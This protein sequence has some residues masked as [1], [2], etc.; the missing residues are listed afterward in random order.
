MKRNTLFGSLV[1][2]AVILAVVVPA[3]TVSR[4]NAERY[5]ARPFFAGIFGPSGFG[6]KDWEVRN[7][8]ALSNRL[9]AYYDF[10]ERVL[11][12]VQVQSNHSIQWFVD[13]QCLSDTLRIRRQ[14][15]DLEKQIEWRRDSVIY[16]DREGLATYVDM[17]VDE[18]RNAFTSPLT[19]TSGVDEI[20]QRCRPKLEEKK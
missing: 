13:Y 1:G 18:F 20:V 16:V 10:D 17:P 5:R 12:V 11:L 14:D 3:V 6:L 19:I 2:L 15:D 4:M 9:Y 7:G 8:L